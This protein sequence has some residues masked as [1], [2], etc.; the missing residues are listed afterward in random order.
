MKK[1][2]QLK[3]LTA[4]IIMSFFILI[5]D[6]CYAQQ[7]RGT[8]DSQQSM[9]KAND[10]FDDSKAIQK[11]LDQSKPGSVIY[12][13]R[14]IYLIDAPLVMKTNNITLKGEDSTVFRFTNK[15][16]YYAM[17]KTRIGMINI[18][19]DN[20]T[21][22]HLIIDQ[23]FTNSGRTDGDNPLI[24]GIMMGC[25]YGGK[26]YI[27]K[28]ITITNCTIYNYY[29]DGIS[30]FHT[31]TDHLRVLNNTLISSYIVGNWKE[32]ETKG[33]QA[34]NVH[35]GDSI[36]ILNNVIRGALD[37]AIAIHF[38]SKD[39]IVAG[40]DITTTG[41][42]ILMNGTQNGVI[43]G[44]KIRYIQNGGSAIWISFESEGKVFN[45]NNALS[46]T[47]NKIFIEKG[48]KIVSAIRLFG[49]GSNIIISNN[50]I[51]TAD[52]QGIGIELKD[53][54]QEVAKKKFFGDNITIQ[55]N[56]IKNFQTGIKRTISKQ[57][58]PPSIKILNNRY[59]NVDKDYDSNDQ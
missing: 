38:Q 20:I 27:T 58:Q 7:I 16:D 41:G 11:M 59:E 56:Q 52:R 9:V 34:I 45:L 15:T 39:V 43:K 50:Q 10:N 47:D 40:N 25:A 31:S 3:T 8:N 46:I 51:E 23:N 13:P 32:A 2:F 29:G 33:E 5:L 24:A 49:P 22:D 4:L 57:V 37:D 36:S 18:C 19:A 55:N 12:L 44:N 35:S 30:V 26:P 17:Y 21:I 1:Y 54:M 53:R 28:N 6:S 42:R 14:G 48:I